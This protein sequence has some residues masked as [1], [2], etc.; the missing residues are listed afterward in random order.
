MVLSQRSHRSGHQRHA[1]LMERGTVSGKGIY[2]YRRVASNKL[3]ALKSTLEE[4]SKT[5]LILIEFLSTWFDPA[6]GCQASSRAPLIVLLLVRS[7]RRRGRQQERTYVLIIKPRYRENN[8]MTTERPPLSNPTVRMYLGHALTF[9][10]LC[11]RRPFEI[12]E[13]T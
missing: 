5:M 3:N 6:A 11:K 10:N 13:Y 1:L 7:S 4:L 2:I 8:N 9:G 12:N